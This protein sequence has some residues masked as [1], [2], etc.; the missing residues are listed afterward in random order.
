MNFK[1]GFT[2]RFKIIAII[3]VVLLVSSESLE[4]A[5]TFVIKG[6]EGYAI[7]SANKD[8][9]KELDKD[10]YLTMKYETISN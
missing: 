7:T 8:F 3:T 2:L 10:K 1:G 9:N 4:T 6:E 5:Q